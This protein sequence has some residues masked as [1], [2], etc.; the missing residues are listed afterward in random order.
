VI[1][2]WDT[3]NARARGLRTHLLSR[4]DLERLGQSADL[5]AL[6]DGL[7]AA[8]FPITDAD[9]FSP[10]ALELAVRRRAGAQL[11]TLARWAGPRA[12]AAAL[13]YDDEDRRN[14]RAILR[15]A[16]DG[17]AAPLRLAGTIPTPSLP[18]RALEELARQPTPRAVAALL[19]AWRHPLG[20][21][22]L[23]AVGAGHADLLRLEVVLSR[24]FTERAV[25][26]AQGG[27]LLEF[28]RE[29]ID[30]ENALAALVLAERSA[31]VT[32]KDAFL[33]GGS[34][35]DIAA[36]EEAIATGT[37]TGAG[38]RLARAF[39]ESRL[40]GPL[41]RAGG[42]GGA[43]EAALLRARLAAQRGAARRDPLG[44]APLLVFVLALRAEADDLRRLIWGLALDA[45]RTLLAAELATT[46]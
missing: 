32:P 15:G 12:A 22:L 23:A 37:A 11:A 42:D 38:A 30:V 18:E 17:A 10:A 24:H 21:P 3:L 39:G 13:L 45:P 34:R 27:P 46:A 20:A 26:L 6:A 41:A 25:R 9:R 19:V 2:R 33:R 1:R 7:R 8:G 35:I 40:A 4:G 36:F 28:V 16:A 14:L 31:D 29:T 43:A 44:P 5:P